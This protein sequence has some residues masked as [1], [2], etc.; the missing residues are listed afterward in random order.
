MTAST[1][2]VP[3][4]IDEVDAGWLTLALRL[5]AGLEGATV[6][7]VRAEQIAIDSGFS[8]LLYR[9]HLTG[10]GVPPTLIAK[11]PAVSEARGAM[12]LLGGYRREL[13]FYRE[14]AGRAPM[15]TPRVYAARMAGDGVDFVLLLEDLSD[16]DNADHLAGL[17]MDRARICIGQ[18]AGLH[19]WSPGPA[20]SVQFPS[21]DTPIARDLLLPAFGPGWAI[22]RAHTSAS[23]PPAVATFA[24]RFTERAVE[25]LPVLTER[26]MLLHGD[27]RADNLFFSGDRMKV[28]D[29]QFTAR[30]AGAADVAYL[31]TQGLPTA[32]RDGH[33]EALLREYL[34][35]LAA[36]GV[37]DYGFDEAWRH[38]RFAAVYL[39]V[40]P[41]ITLNGWDA[42]PE[43]SRRLCL[44]LTDRAVAAIDAI[45]ALEVFG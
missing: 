19:A 30:G 28:V 26:D 14:V 44:T 29:F 20:V 1:A 33:D 21:I 27:I 25:A 15:D 41:V 6:D 11:L 10:T 2:A 35:R 43:R 5:D 3:G 45:D 36:H 42:M 23:V 16:W 38:Y 9:L 34:D 17:S 37:A 12:E 4:G 7:D 22:Y 13:S 18:L 8:S 32:V 31:V 40:L 39:M 24:E